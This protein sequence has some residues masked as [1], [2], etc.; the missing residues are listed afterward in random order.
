VRLLLDTH[1]FLWFVI[2][3]PKLGEMARALI[4][5]VGNEKLLS[6]GSLW[7]MAKEMS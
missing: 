7:E 6:A 2:G 5:D 1:S 3:R 4:G